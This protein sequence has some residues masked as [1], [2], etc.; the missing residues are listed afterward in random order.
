MGKDKKFEVGGRELTAEQA[1]ALLWRYKRA[2]EGLTIGGSEFVNDPEYCAAHIRE[3]FE[4]ERNFGK[5]IGRKEAERG[6]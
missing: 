1:V 5:A 4:H 6:A 3:R 2:L